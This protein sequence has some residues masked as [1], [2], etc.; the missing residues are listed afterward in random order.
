M[1]VQRRKTAGSEKRSEEWIE[2]FIDFI[3]YGFEIKE[4]IV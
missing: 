2:P 1:D 4:Q 3:F